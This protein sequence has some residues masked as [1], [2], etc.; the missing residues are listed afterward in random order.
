M[1]QK[2]CPCSA[3]SD[4][5]GI[6]CSAERLLTVQHKCCGGISGQHSLMQSP[7]TKC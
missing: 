7:V 1:A 6:I 3:I 4:N 5:L 2:N